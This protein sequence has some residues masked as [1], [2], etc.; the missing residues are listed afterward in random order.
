MRS[1]RL[2]R[3]RTPTKSEVVPAS[4]ISSRVPTN[5]NLAAFVG[6]PLLAITIFILSWDA[7]VVGLGSKANKSATSEPLV[8]DVLVRFIFHVLLAFTVAIYT[9]ITTLFQKLRKYIKDRRS[10]TIDESIP[11]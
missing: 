5:I 10:R 9:G 11:S 3:G 8:I 1:T 2:R 4:C 6:L 7:S